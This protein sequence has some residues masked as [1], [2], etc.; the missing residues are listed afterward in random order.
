MYW[1][2][3]CY[4]SH[5]T[6]NYPWYYNDPTATHIAMLRVYPNSIQFNWNEGSLFCQPKR[7]ARLIYGPQL[8]QLQKTSSMY[9]SLALI[10]CWRAYRSIWNFTNLCLLV[11]WI[12]FV[13]YQIA[14]FTHW[15]KYQ[16][17]RPQLKWDAVVWL[18]RRQMNALVQR[19]IGSSE[20]NRKQK[21]EAAKTKLRKTNKQTSQFI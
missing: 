17:R 1:K 6:S 2:L 4:K 16:L 19:R 11:T 21:K 13:S 12:C 3:M 20:E 10:I 8:N 7:A 9:I 5:K 18:P 14:Y 15:R